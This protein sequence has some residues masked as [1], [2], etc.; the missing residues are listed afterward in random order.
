MSQFTQLPG[1]ESAEPLVRAKECVEW[2]KQE[3]FKTRHDF[4]IF[5]VISFLSLLIYESLQNGWLSN[6]FKSKK[7]R[8]RWLKIA[9]TV[10]KELMSAGFLWYLFVLFFR[11]Y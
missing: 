6:K 7:E 3:R 10:H 2:C 9:Y 8:E 5:F 4:I 11:K 1:M